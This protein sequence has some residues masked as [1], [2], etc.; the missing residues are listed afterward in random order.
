MILYSKVI[1]VPDSEPVT[2][3]E[4]K[5]HLEVTGDSKNTY[6][7]SLIKTARRMCEAYSG[8]SFVTQERKIILDKFPCGEILVPYGP[9]QSIDSFTYVKPDLTTGTLVEGTDFFF[10]DHS[11]VARLFPLEDGELDVW[12]DTAY[13]PNCVIIEYTA[14]YDDVSGIPLP[15]QIKEAVLLQVAAMFENRQDELV[16]VASISR[17]DMDSKAILDSVKVYWNANY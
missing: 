15:E 17:L 5:T 14:G 2:L 9:V 1:E 13:R 10:D 7:T 3:S 8:L 12:P 16:G 11:E 4:A 6:I